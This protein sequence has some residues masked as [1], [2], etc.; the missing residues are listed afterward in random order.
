MEKNVINLA[1][2]TLKHTNKAV[3]NDGGMGR[4]R[5]TLYFPVC[6]QVILAREIKG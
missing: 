2:P 1:N 4:S 3:T 5:Q 6:S